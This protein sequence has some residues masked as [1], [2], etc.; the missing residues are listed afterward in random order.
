MLHDLYKFEIRVTIVE[1]M[2]FSSTEHRSTR[3]LNSKLR[4]YTGY[5]III[6]N[7]DNSVNKIL[8]N[9]FNIY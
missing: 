6:S 1:I 9:E 4:F 8:I 2:D 3:Y 5:S 7:F